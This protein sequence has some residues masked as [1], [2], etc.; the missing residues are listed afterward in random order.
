VVLFQEKKRCRE[1]PASCASDLSIL[2]MNRCKKGLQRSTTVL[3]LT[4]AMYL[5][6]R[7][8]WESIQHGGTDDTSAGMGE[9]HTLAN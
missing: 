3:P 9:T 5:C 8:K 6:T 4:V 1:H 7:N 2:C